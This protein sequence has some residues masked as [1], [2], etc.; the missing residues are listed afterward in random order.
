MCASSKTDATTSDPVYRKNPH[1]TQAYRITLKMKM[2]QG[3][4][5]GSRVRFYQM[6][7]RKQCTQIEPI[8]GVWSKHDEDDIP[9]HP[10]KRYASTYVTTI[11]ADG[12]DDADYYAKGVCRWDSL[13]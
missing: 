7:N 9:I 4:L 8:A 12:M 5:T 11:Y 6:T 10:E 3:R 13:A 2:R 1:P